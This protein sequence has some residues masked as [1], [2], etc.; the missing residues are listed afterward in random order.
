MLN[1][2]SEEWGGNEEL[3]DEASAIN[4]PFFFFFLPTTINYTLKRTTNTIQ[5]K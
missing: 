2:C 4:A 5:L 1:M 3:L